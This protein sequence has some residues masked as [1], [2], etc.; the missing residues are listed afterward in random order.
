MYKITNEN[1]VIGVVTTPAW[2]KM[3]DNGSFVLCDEEVAQG[4]VVNNTVYHVLG[5]PELARHDAV[6]LGYIDEIAYQQE[7]EA[8]QLQMNTALAELSILIASAMTP[9]AE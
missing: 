1:N 8:K 9:T 7:Q 6:V 3:Q 4:V 2:V 5:K